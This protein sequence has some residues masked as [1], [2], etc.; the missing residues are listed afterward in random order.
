MSLVELL[1]LGRHSGP[2]HRGALWLHTKP[3]SDL[4]RRRLQTPA[5][6]SVHLLSSASLPPP[7]PLHQPLPLTQVDISIQRI[8]RFHHCVQMVN[9]PIRENVN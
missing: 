3:P 7:P 9:A 1:L 2:V 5:Y 6:L 8:S 4:P